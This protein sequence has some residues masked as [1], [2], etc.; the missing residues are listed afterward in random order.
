MQSTRV[1]ILD[2]LET[3]W[4]IGSRRPRGDQWVVSLTP[5]R[6]S[7][8]YIGSTLMR[9]P[10]SSSFRVIARS[11]PAN[12]GKFQRCCMEGCAKV[13]CIY[14]ELPSEETM[15]PLSFANLAV[16]VRETTLTAGRTTLETLASTKI[17]FT[18]RLACTYPCTASNTSEGSGW[19]RLIP[20]NMNGRKS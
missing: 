8:E 14:S 1:F 17:D 15:A 18:Y 4:R 12:A 19:L 13:A 16:Y 9:S 6:V 20:P 2:R 10:E 7:Q 11:L 5:R 3:G